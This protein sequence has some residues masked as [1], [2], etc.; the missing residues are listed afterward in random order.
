M[1]A[2][3]RRRRVGTSDPHPLRG[4]PDPL[5]QRPG[6]R[7][8]PSRPER[9]QGR[10]QTGGGR[11]GHPVLPLPRLPRQVPDALPQ[12]DPRGPR[13]D[14]AVRHRADR[15]HQTEPVRSR[16]GAVPSMPTITRRTYLALSALAPLAAGLLARESRSEDISSRDVL[17][18]RYFP[19]LALT[20]H[21]GRQVRFYDDLIKD[22]IVTINFMYKQCED[23]RCP[24]TTANLVRVQKLLGSRVGHDILT[25]SFTLAPH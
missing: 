2:D 10:A 24:V 13:D 14:A 9:P 8:I 16:K 6:A 22:K 18:D 11:H 7:P 20:P 1:D 23:G 4:V 17:R 25:Y 15:R 12:H 5:D 21:E 19:N 3:Q